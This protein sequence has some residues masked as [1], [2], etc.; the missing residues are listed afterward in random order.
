M[1]FCSFVAWMCLCVNLNLF[2]QSCCAPWQSGVW[3]WA[4]EQVPPQLQPS[5]CRLSLLGWGRP[6]AAVLT[7]VI[8]EAWAL[9]SLTSLILCLNA[10]TLVLKCLWIGWALIFCF[11]SNW[12]SFGSCK[13]LL[14]FLSERL[15]R[16]LPVPDRH[17]S[18]ISG[19]DVK[20][21]SKSQTDFLIQTILFSHHFK[22]CP[23]HFS[24]ISHFST[25]SYTV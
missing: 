21:V 13:F 2:L 11:S 19:V 25:T 9:P 6:A 15:L 16:F 17:L 5:H 22:S 1:L 3:G 4:G 7:E 12:G 23:L 18:S 20:L 8:M 24:P 10:N 14:F